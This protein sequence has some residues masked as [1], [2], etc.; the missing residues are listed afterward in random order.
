MVQVD[1]HILDSDDARARL[2]YACRLT[3]KARERGHRVFLRVDDDG[4]AQTLDELLWTFRD[5]SFIP[6]AIDGPGA[7]DEPVLI[8]TG[9]APSHGTGDLLV[10]LAGKP[11]A[12]PKAF[13]RIVEIG[14]NDP[15]VRRSARQRFRWYRDQG[16]EPE[17][18]KV[19]Q[20]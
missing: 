14:D 3:D 19:G 20:T 2:V 5:R 15:D 8:G 18:R 17:H 9:D 12:E 11:V 4:T 16:I 7:P 6:H 1:F 13:Q 10:N